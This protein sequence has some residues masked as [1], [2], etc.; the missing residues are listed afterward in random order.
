MFISLT[1]GQTPPAD[2]IASVHWRQIDD[3]HDQH[4]AGVMC[5]ASAGA[6]CFTVSQSAMTGT[7]V[8]ASHACHLP[9]GP[10]LLRIDEVCFPVGAI[11]YRHTHAGA[12]IR[13]LVRGALQIEADDHTQT[14]ASGD[15]WFEGTQSP[16][17][18][19]ALQ[20][21]GVTSFV[22]A[23]IIPARYAGQS[24]FQLCDPADADL[25][26]LQATHRHIDLPFQVDAG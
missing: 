15:T 8:T 17:R 4:P 19:T 3:L 18:A 12:G 1:K 26:R 21:S 5:A 23:M 10:V 9:N 6:L 20:T 16:V 14:I 2:H 22:R 7:N 13:H 24:T 25:P 11:A